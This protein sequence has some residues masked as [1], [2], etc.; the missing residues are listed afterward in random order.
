MR[1]LLLNLY[2]FI[3]SSAAYATC[4][5]E[6]AC[7][8][9]DVRIDVANECMCYSGRCF[10]VFTAEN[11]PLRTTN[12]TGIIKPLRTGTTSDSLYQTLKTSDFTYNNDALRMGIGANDSRQKWIHKPRNCSE[13]TRGCIGVPCSEWVAF[14]RFITSS[15]FTKK[16]SVCGGSQTG[17]E[18]DL[19]RNRP[20][21]ADI[22]TSSLR[23]QARPRATSLR[24]QARP[25]ATSL[26]PVVRPNSVALGKTTQQL[27]NI[28]ASRIRSGVSPSNNSR[29]MN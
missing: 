4:N 2:F 9:A 21:V 25:R 5:V 6:S 10:K 19:Y 1:Y 12:G 23:P 15:G 24:P 29:S 14:K 17:E 28:A 7:G 16:I 22:T 3:F 27:V 13:K 11:G 18:S 20:P 8:S 26:R